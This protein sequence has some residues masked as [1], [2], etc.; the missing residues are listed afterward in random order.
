MFANT[1][2][3]IMSLSSALPL[4]EAVQKTLATFDSGLFLAAS[5]S[6][7]RT[8]SPQIE[9]HQGTRIFDVSF[10]NFVSLWEKFGM[11][12]TR[13]DESLILHESST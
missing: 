6:F 8:S 10:P 9:F 11:R 4:G 2:N 7:L 13:F 1:V 5:V 3:F 12:L